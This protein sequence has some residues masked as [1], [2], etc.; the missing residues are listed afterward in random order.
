MFSLRLSP[1]TELFAAILLAAAVHSLP[2]AVPSQPGAA[3]LPPAGPRLSLT[4]PKHDFG[5]VPKGE[6]REHVFEFSNTGQGAL[7]I[8]RVEVTCGCTTTGEWDRQVAA[9]QSGRIPIHFSTSAFTGQ[10]SRSILVHS[11]DPLQPVQ[12]LLVDADVWVPIEVSPTSVMIQYL[13]GSRAK[14]LRTVKI[15]NRQKEPLSLSAPASSHQAFAATIVAVQ[16]GFEF[17]LRIETAGPVAPGVN[18]G[19]ISMQ[20]SSKEMPRIKV[21]VYMVERPAVVVSPPTLIVP[22]SIQAQPYRAA[23]T[24]T[25]MSPERLTLSQPRVPAGCE[26]VALQENEPG[27]SY[28]LSLTF[29][30]G[31]TPAREGV[32]EVT[33][34]SN[35]P[36]HPVLK[37]PVIRSTR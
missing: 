17:D 15:R 6:T 30:Q 34:N 8:I 3:A 26:D 16:E 10:I 19:E 9:G 24:I 28:V 25:A 36:R 2:A 37:V 12:T 4:Q 14:E 33:L 35:H 23:V 11:N 31:Y 7:E 27:R 5:R 21:A 32:T 29:P 18:S 20:T 22:A 1:R 13:S